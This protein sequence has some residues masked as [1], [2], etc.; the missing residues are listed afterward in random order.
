MLPLS[1]FLFPFRLFGKRLLLL[2]QISA[3]REIKILSGTYK[4]G[5]GGG[6]L[7]VTRVSSTKPLYLTSV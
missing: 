3:E 5:E 6:D 4:R 2:R 1:L 7:P